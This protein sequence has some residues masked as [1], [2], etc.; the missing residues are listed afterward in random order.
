MT[1][2]EI[3]IQ[4]Q[5][6]RAKY[7]FKRSLNTFILVI[8]GLITLTLYLQQGNSILTQAFYSLITIPVSLYLL[9]EMAEYSNHEKVEIYEIREK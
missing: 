7:S 6:I 3:S 8:L 9:V 2:K 4:E 1:K 5:E